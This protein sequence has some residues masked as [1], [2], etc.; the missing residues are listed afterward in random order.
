MVYVVAMFRF[1]FMKPFFYL[2]LEDLRVSKIP[3][4]I[5]YTISFSIITTPSPIALRGLTPPA[6][7][8]SPAS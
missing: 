1:S 2:W 3:S 8:S 6:I 5:F 7:A 4:H